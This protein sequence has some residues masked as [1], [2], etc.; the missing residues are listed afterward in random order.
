MSKPTVFNYTDYVNALERIKQLE[1]ELNRSATWT[2]DPG[3][4]HYVYVCSG[5][6]YNAIEPTLFCPGCGA[7][8]EVLNDNR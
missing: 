2:R 4:L 5:C 8:M 1:N 6:G 3:P 7:R